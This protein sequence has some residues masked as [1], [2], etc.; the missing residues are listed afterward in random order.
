MKKLVAL[1]VMVVGVGLAGLAQAAI[2]NSAHD[3]TDG[4]KGLKGNSGT[5][6]AVDESWNARGE[7]CRVCHVPHDHARASQRYLNGL[8]W[9]HGVSVASY[10]MYD[11][12]W[13]S[14]IT[15]AQSAQPDGTSKLCLA[16]HDGTVAIDTF[17]KYA[18]GAILFDGTA[19]GYA[20]G[21]KVPGFLDGDKL[22]LRGT[23][24][25]SIAFPAGQAGDGKNFTDPATATWMDNATVA[26]TLD[27]GKMQCS[28]CHDVHSSTGGVATGSHLLRQAQTVE[29]GGVASGLCL[30]C[31]VK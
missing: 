30:T 29:Q 10:T 8:L 14:T 28:T 6:T 13:S 22:D 25:I 9:N 18:G 11:T 1:G 12:A 16:C 15:G 21:Y 20:A 24:P 19:T 31:H 26:S 2:T 17:D 5:P 3:F 7:I 23:H 4:V 27:N